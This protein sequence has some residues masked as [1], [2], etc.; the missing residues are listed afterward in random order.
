MNFRWVG[1]IVFVCLVVV[2]GILM[3]PWE[4]RPPAED[5]NSSSPQ[6]N[7]HPVADVLEKPS[8]L[9]YAYGSKFEPPDGYVF[10]G[11]GQWVDY[12]DKLT[13]KVN[14]PSLQPASELLFIDIGDTPRGWNPST[15]RMAFERMERNQVIPSIDIAFRGNHVDI[16]SL[17]DPY[18]GIDEEI[19]IS[20]KYQQRIR[21]VAQ[22]VKEYGKPVFVRLGGEFNGNWNGYQ[23]YAYPKAFRTAVN[24]FRE[25]GA[26]NAAFVWCYM[27]AAPDDYFDMDENGNAKWFPGDE[28]VDWY[29]IDVFNPNQFSGSEYRSD[30]KLTNYGKTLAFLSAA[31]AHGKPVFI[32]ESSSVEVGLDPSLKTGKAVWSSWFVPYFAFIRDHP[33]IKGFVYINYDWTQAANYK[34]QGWKNGDL[35]E[36]EYVLQLFMEELVKDFY[37]KS[38]QRHWLMEYDRFT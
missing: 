23:P 21:D 4:D 15:I 19:P 16:S 12:N 20:M 22:I 31:E 10:Y 30:G 29:S 5:T 14:N 17:D 27:P 26:D 1:V 8:G 24:I 13:A 38:P 35:T 9:T 37:I 3:V 33:I 25:E 36:N 28:Y 34:K 6:D 2:M 32:A 18:Y 11:Y 7:N